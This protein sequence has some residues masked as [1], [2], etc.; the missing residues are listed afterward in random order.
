MIATPADAAAGVAQRMVEAG[1]RS[2]LNF[3]PIEV[4]VPEGITVRRVDLA[5]EL[6]I[7]SYHLAQ[8]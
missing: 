3:A 5:M 6:Q 8:S 2:I 7:L 1:I 4:T